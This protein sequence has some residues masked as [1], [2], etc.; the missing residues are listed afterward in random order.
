MTDVRKEII[1]ARAVCVR[2]CVRACVRVCV[3][4]CVC[5]LFCFW[6]TVRERALASGS[7][8]RF[9]MVDTKHTCA[10]KR[11]KQ[12]GRGGHGEQVRGKQH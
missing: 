11:T 5:V 6:S 4:V 3:C 8:F 12:P 10:C 1:S 9:N 2:A 7:G